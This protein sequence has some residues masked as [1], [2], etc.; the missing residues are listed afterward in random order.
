MKKSVILIHG[1]DGKMPFVNSLIAN[2]NTEKLQFFSPRFPT[3]QNREKN[4]DGWGKVMDEFV[5]NGT[6]NENSTVVAHSIGTAAFIKYLTDRNMKIDKY[7]SVAGFVDTINPSLKN[8]AKLEMHFK[9][10]GY[11]ITENRLEHAS[12][13]VKERHS[14]YSDNDPLFAK[15]ELL[16]YAY[17]L[18]ADVHFRK[19]HGHFSEP[20]DL[21]IAGLAE[22][23]NE[24]SVLDI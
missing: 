24:K 13:L 3:F 17:H 14:F 7:I 5:H 10:Y 2:S 20:H 1:A 12:K 11:A 15:D 8:C 6:L 23:V 21:S 16:R 19:N 22:I 4:F 18:G 9:K